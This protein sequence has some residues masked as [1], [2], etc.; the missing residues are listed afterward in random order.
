M[1]LKHGEDERDR[2]YLIDVAAFDKLNYSSRVYNG[3]YTITMTD[4]TSTE[5]VATNLYL[6]DRTVS[7][8]TSIGENN[9]Y[10]VSF[11]T[12]NHPAGYRLDRVRMHVPEHEARP[13]MVLHA[14]TPGLPGD[15]V[16]DLLQPNQVQHHRPYAGDNH[17]PVTFRAAHCGDEALLDANT[18]YWMVLEG[19]GYSTVFTDSD[20][21]H[22]D[23]SGWTIGD[24]SATLVDNSLWF[25]VPFTGP[26]PVEIWAS[27]R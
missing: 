1:H 17:L 20:D 5:Q 19:D 24:V 22:T 26:I 11:T 21:Q 10:A 9:Q 12:G 4:I 23:R 13:D 15:P 7:T 27:K 8:H 6:G 2:R 25:I 14:D 16:C 18:T 3:P